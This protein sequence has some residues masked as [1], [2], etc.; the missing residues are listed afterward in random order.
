MAL[1]ASSGYDLVDGFGHYAGAP[2]S[3]AFGKRLVP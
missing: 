3:R 2:Q 1:Y